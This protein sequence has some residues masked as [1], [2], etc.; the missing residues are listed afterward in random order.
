MDGTLYRKNRLIYGMV[1]LT[2]GTQ[3]TPR[4]MEY[5]MHVS[6]W[7]NTHQR[8]A[9]FHFII[10]TPRLLTYKKHKGTHYITADFSEG[11]R[12]ETHPH[13]Q[14]TMAAA[15]YIHCTPLIYMLGSGD[16]S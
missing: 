10:H 2:V 4:N 12:V 9:Y 14:P 3:Y 11:Y 15:E 1:G 8:E 6:E 13:M 7:P 5:Y 16:A